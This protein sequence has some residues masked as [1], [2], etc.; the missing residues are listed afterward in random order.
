MAVRPPPLREKDRSSPTWLNWDKEI[1]D[2]VNAVDY[3]GK[4]DK[5]DSPT[6]DNFASLDSDGDIQ[7]SGYDHTSFAGASHS[8]TASTISL[9]G[10][11]TINGKTTTKQTVYTVATGKTMIPFM[12]CVRSPSNTLVGLV[13]MDIGGDAAAG[14]WIQQITLNAFTATTDYGFVL[15]P[16]QAAG[17][18]IVPVKKT[19][20]AAAT[21]FGVKINT[22]SNGAATFTI[23]L[24]GYLF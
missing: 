5:V 13:D 8:H 7:D 4:A 3:T 6:V 21:A 16:E 15:Q 22:V 20:Y 18:P 12:L 24:F 17:P 19:V 14:D 9:L 23:D 1:A 2:E 10:S 11:A